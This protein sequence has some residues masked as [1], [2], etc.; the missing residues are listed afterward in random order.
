VNFLTEFV[1]IFWLICMAIAMLV[2]LVWLAAQPVKLIG[3][4]LDRRYGSWAE[5]DWY[6]AV[7]FLAIIL[8]LAAV[9]ALNV[10]CANG[11]CQ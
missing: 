2:A 8:V 5:G 3:R 4:W 7:T 11:Q 9:L 10:M 6:M 1:S